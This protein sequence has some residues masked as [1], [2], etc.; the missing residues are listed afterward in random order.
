MKLKISILRI[1][2]LG[3]LLSPFM[4]AYN[5]AQQDEFEYHSNFAQKSGGIKST[6]AL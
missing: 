3:L 5:V 6:P 1:I 2:L 4:S